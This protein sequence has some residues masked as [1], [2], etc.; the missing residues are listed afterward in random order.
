M[1]S[2][3]KFRRLPLNPRKKSKENDNK[4]EK[5]IVL[6]EN[7]PPKWYVVNN[8]HKK[9]IINPCKKGPAQQVDTG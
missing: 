4:S 7:D 5:K 9:S 1:I 2:N 6:D 3:D 8:R